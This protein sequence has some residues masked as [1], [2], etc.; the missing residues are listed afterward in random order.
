MLN[1]FFWTLKKLKS[2][3]KQGI[4][5]VLVWLKVIIKKTTKHQNNLYCVINDTNP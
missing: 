1:Q 2:K 3:N 4:P 5:H